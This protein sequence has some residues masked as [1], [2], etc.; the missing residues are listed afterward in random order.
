MSSLLKGPSHA[1][2]C[3]P[4]QTPQRQSTSQISSND[5]SSTY[6]LF[7]GWAISASTLGAAKYARALKGSSRDMPVQCTVTVEGKLHSHRLAK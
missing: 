4:V 3:P 5:N 7:Q 2:P 6:T 1:M